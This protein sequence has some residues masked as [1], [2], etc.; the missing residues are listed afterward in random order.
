MYLGRVDSVLNKPMPSPV[1]LVSIEDEMEVFSTAS[2]ESI[3]TRSLLIPA[4]ADVVIHT[5]GSRVAQCFL[6]DI[7]TDFA[8][9]IPQMQTAVKTPAG[10]ALYSHIR[11][12]NDIVEHAAYL[13]DARPSNGEAFEILEHWVGKLCLDSSLIADQRVAKAVSMIKENYTENL[14]VE[15]VASSVGL[16]VP[17]LSQLF[18]QIVG[19]PIR[20]YRLWYR[21][22]ATAA[23]IGQGYTLTDAAVAC[24]F[25]DYPQLCRVFKELTGGKPAA[26]R[27]N[28]EI[29][30]L[31]GCY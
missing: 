31:S 11:H 18:K 15:S 28:T 9:L 17:R 23:K 26:A 8:R 1:L 30:V 3:R 4:A 19:M 25:A 21:I 13:H 6:D 20:R 12:E 2:N 10:K 29:R 7:G 24:G 16:S 27:D 5:H 22:F 14:S